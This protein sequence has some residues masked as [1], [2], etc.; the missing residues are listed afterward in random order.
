MH[1]FYANPFLG[2]LTFSFLICA[3]FTVTVSSQSWPCQSDKLVR[4]RLSDALSLSRILAGQISA[5]RINMSRRWPLSPFNATNIGFFGP[6]RRSNKTAIKPQQ[7]L[8]A[9]IR[10]LRTFILLIDNST[11][12]LRS[13]Q[14]VEELVTN[15]LVDLKRQTKTLNSYL[16]Y[17]VAIITFNRLGK[18]STVPQGGQQTNTNNKPAIRPIKTKPLNMKSTSTPTIQDV[19]RRTQLILVDFRS[20]VLTLASDL[21]KIA[22][23]TCN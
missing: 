17:I 11:S 23:Q 21:Q 20:N 8:K 22:A 15:K 1:S 10:T 12:Q 3:I 2:S 7:I 5:L 6:R 4:R 19:A 14:V 18:T 13:F 9:N 16:R